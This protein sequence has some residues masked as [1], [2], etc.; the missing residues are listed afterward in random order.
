MI[1]D[2]HAHYDDEQFD[3]DREDLL[4][5]IF[6]ANIDKIVNVGADMETSKQS[7]ALAK[8]YPQIYA[9]VGVHPSDIACLSEDAYTELR[10]L[11]AEDK[12]VAIGEIGLDYYWD[13]EPDVQ[14]AQREAFK[15]QLAL[16]RELNLPVIVHSR[17]AAKDT[18]DILMA[19][20]PVENPG[21]IHCYSYSVEQ[22]KEYVKRGYYIG[23]GG[24]VTFK[25]SKVLKQV[26]E[27]IP[28]ERIVVETDC[29]YL[30]PEPNRGKRNASLNLPYIVDKIA[31]IKG[32]S[33]KE[34][35]EVT[36]EN[37]LK[38]YRL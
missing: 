7:V 20:E 34:V 30:A 2:T 9:A 21:I 4:R 35:E 13:K 26:V 15:R 32:I 11:A 38:V 19:E 18:M 36:Y 24:V 12:V 25:N 5:E 28:L 27:E 10:Q 31:Q 8:A 6:S 17:D 1:F 3:T 37:A 22:A 29:P 16:A 33:G 23:V 14:A